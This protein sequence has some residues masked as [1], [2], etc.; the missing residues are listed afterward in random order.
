MRREA[1]ELLPHAKVLNAKGLP[2]RRPF[3]APINWKPP[4][5][6]EAAA[7]YVFAWMNKESKMRDTIRTM[8]MGG[9]AYTVHVECLCTS[10]YMSYGPGKQLRTM[11]ND[12]MS[13]ICPG[14]TIAARKRRKTM[15]ESAS[16]SSGCI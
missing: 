3:E 12:A 11:T 1:E 6:V 14:H 7:A 9:L 4:A 10:A 2:M 5:D 15:A 8:Q 13:R 16:T